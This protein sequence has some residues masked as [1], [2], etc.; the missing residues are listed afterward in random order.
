MGFGGRDEAT[1]LG[2]S[3]DGGAAR[4]VTEFGGR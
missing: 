1:R 2:E 4:C 3:S